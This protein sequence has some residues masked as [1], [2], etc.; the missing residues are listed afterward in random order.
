MSKK[1]IEVLKTF[2]ETGDR[3]TQQQFHDWLD[4]YHHKDAAALISEK[5][6]DPATSIVKLKFTDNT[7]LEFALTENFTLSS[8][9]ELAAAFNQKVDK[10]AGKALSENDYNDQEKAKVQ[11][12]K[13]H[14][15]NNSL[16]VPL[17]LEFDENNKTVWNNGKGNIDT[18]TSFGDGALISVNT[19]T[20]NRNTAFGDYALS[21]NLMGH[22][23][24]SIGYFSMIN[25]LVAN[26][27]ISLGSLSLNDVK[28]GGFNIGLGI[29]ARGGGVGGSHNISI[30]TN[31]GA[32]NN[33]NDDTE[34]GEQ[35][36]NSIHIGHEAVSDGST[37]NVIV[38][39]HE[40][41]GEGSNT[42]VIGNDQ[43]TQTHLRGELLLDEGITFDLLPSLVFSLKNRIAFLAD[44]V[45]S[46]IR[47]YLNGVLD[48]DFSAITGVK[49]LTV[50]NESGTIAIKEN[51]NKGYFM[52][53]DL[54]LDD[55]YVTYTDAP[56]VQFNCKAG[57]TYK[58]EVNGQFN[59]VNSA[60]GFGYGFRLSSGTGTI[61]GIATTTSDINE[62][63]TYQAKPITV[64]NSNNS[65]DKSVVE[66]VA[67][68]QDDEIYPFD[69]NFIFKCLTDG[70]FK[71]TLAS[72]SSTVGGTFKAGTGIIVNEIN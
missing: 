15:D 40:A 17:H 30:G 52:L 28:L 72:E 25:S 19:P 8:I 16:H 23:N 27:C 44:G 61:N 34:T 21:S 50:E 66:R 47:P 18:N 45:L 56:N 26:H 59:N 60:N 70:V 13:D 58:I 55:G 63:S 69:G 54:F 49:T 10:I 46:L 35:S 22:S 57:K 3:P 12:N 67:L 64:I 14:A 33:Y 62:S 37:E 43:T 1:S 39:G 38:I 5:S 29:A 53:S 20:A 31:A 48:I 24:T 9:P 51:I 68:A 36:F 41:E 65:D 32:N 6:Y 71:M 42:T 2:F 4:S 11:S 7:V